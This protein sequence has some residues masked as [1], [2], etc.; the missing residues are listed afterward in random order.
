MTMWMVRAEE[1][2]RL[3]QP[4]LE[5][6]VVAIGWSDVG[7]LSILK[8]REEILEKVEENWPEW[9]PQAKFNAAGMLF[10][11]AHQMQPGDWVITYNK[12]QRIYAVGKI[13]G[14]YQFNP[15][16]DE[17]DPNV[18]PV[19]WL[20]KGLSR[21]LLLTATRNSLGSTLTLFLVPDDAQNN[22]LHVIDHGTAQ[23]VDE[24]IV[25]EQEEDLLQ[26]IEA[27]SLE[28]IKDRIAGLSWQD[29]QIL[30]A[31]V[32]R[33]M[34][35]KT[36]ISPAGSDR[37]K[38]IIAS[39]DGLGFEDPRII[40]EVKHRPQSTMGTQEIRSFLGGRHPGDKGLYVSTGGFSKEAHYEAERANI[41]VTLIGLDEL[42]EL[43]VGNYDKMDTEVQR[44][45]P[46]K[47]V[48][49]PIG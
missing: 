31:G 34:G 45:V 29:L 17:A 47:R 37:G 42:V 5:Q 32:L 11:F 18:R 4:F 20:E 41:P 2:S 16:F 21:D 3:Y 14:P 43:M 7:D 9:K 39:P 19:E 38:D 26:D 30:V 40:V 49:W 44:L 36:R 8:S 12:I 24:A 22:V 13:S 15:G 35:Y 25:E 1:G 46:L 48:F 6:G 33:A 23:S 28:F 27:R 10:R